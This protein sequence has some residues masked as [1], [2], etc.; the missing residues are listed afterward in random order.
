MK[1]ILAA[2]AL[3]AGL[4]GAAAQAQEYYIGQILM[5]G[6]NFCPRGTA[7]AQGQLLSIAQNQALFSLL[8]TQFGGD[9]RTT[10]GLPD[11]RG[12]MAVNQGTG[13]GLPNYVMG[14]KGGANTVT[15]SEVNLPPHTHA[16]TGTPSGTATPGSSPSPQDNLPA[17]TTTA[18]AYAPAG[19]PAVNMAANSVAVT[20]GSTGGGQAVNVTNPFQVVNFCVVTMGIYPS[21][22]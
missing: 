13:P 7:P 12:R 6:W 16:A 10:F 1:R 2:T 4:G 20:V 15:L 22:N 9:G 5:G 21:R 14:Q 3:V 19:G 18:P 17:L 11:L 8:G